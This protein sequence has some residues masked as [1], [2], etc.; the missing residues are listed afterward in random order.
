[1]GPIPFTKAKF[2]RDSNMGY[3]SPLPQIAAKRAINDETRPHKKRCR[4][5][6]FEVKEYI[7]R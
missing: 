2:L 1:M 5:V 4:R 6:R 7:F 3:I